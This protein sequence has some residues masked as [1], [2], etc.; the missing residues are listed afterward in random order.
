MLNDWAVLL[1]NSIAITT[2]KAKTLE[3][4]QCRQMLSELAAHRIAAQAQG[5]VAGELDD[6]EHKAE[7]KVV[8]KWKGRNEQ[9]SDKAQVQHGDDDDHQD[10]AVEAA[11]AKFSTM[12]PCLPERKGQRSVRFRLLGDLPTL[13]LLG[14]RYNTTGAPDEG[15]A[16]EP[17]SAR[18]K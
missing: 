5:M 8:S 10:R 16:G 4:R 11:Q 15:L 14:S 3:R 2:P 12:G 17:V 7:A 6:P 9:P 13:P 18:A 1:S